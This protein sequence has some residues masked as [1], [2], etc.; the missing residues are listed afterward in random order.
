M[1]S[2]AHTP[3]GGTPA[4]MNRL[5]QDLYKKFDNNIKQFDIKVNAQYLY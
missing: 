1:L 5:L 4:Q 2:L 3:A